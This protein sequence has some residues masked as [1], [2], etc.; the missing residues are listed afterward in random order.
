[1]RDNLA[2]RR[3]AAR[4]LAALQAA[5]GVRLPLS[6]GRI[7]DTELV[8]TLIHD[9][10]PDEAPEQAWAL[11]NGY[12]FPALADAGDEARRA[13]AICRLRLP[14]TLGRG[15]WQRQIAR[16]AMLPP[17]Y[18]L[19]SIA[20]GAVTRQTTA[21]VPERLD[22]MR[23]ALRTAPAWQER[24]ARYA[25]AGVH[26]FY[27]DREPHEVEIPGRIADLARSAPQLTL[28]RNGSERLPLSVSQVELEETATWMDQVAVGTIAAQDWYKRIHDARIAAIT[29]DG[30]ARRST[31]DVDGLLHLIGMVASG[32]SSLFTVLAVHLARQ[33]K[34]VTIV[35]GDVAALLR[36]LAIFEIFR[37]ADT[38]VQAIP[39]IGRSTRT[40]HLNRLHV[41][42]AQRAGEAT[43]SLSHP[44]YSMLSTICPL[45]GLR[46]DVTPIPPGKEP[47][48]SLYARADADDPAAGFDESGHGRRDCPVMP[49]CPVHAPTRALGDAHIWLATPASL[50]A[51]SP[52][53]PLVAEQLR[54]AELIMRGSD[55]CLI[56]EAD[57]V[58]IQSDDRFAQ[59]E[60]LVGP[61]DSWLDRL[62]NQVARQVYRSGRPEIGRSRTVDRWLTAHRN[63]QQ[64]VDRLYGWLRTHAA[65]RQWL[66]DS[67]FSGQR[68]LQR[69]AREIE[70]MGLASGPFEEAATAFELFGSGS[71]N[72]RA[73]V[74][75]PRAWRDAI[76]TELDS[77]DQDAALALI[78]VWL[79]NTLEWPT[80][81]TQQQL[82]VLAHRTL[83]AMIVSVLDH[84]LQDMVEEWNEASSTIDLDRGSGGLFYAPSDALVRQ[85]PEPA[86]GRVVGFQYW[87]LQGSGNGELRFFHIKGLGRA[88]LY[89]IHD[90][91]R[92]SDGIAG[93]HVVLASGTSWAPTSWR[94]HLHVP[95]GAVLLPNRTDA[96]AQT[97]CFF[98]PLPDPD[99]QQKM[100]T[101]SGLPPEARLRNMRMMVRELARKRGIKGLSMFDQEFALLPTHR[102]RILLIVG[103]Y[104]EAE[105]VAQTLSDAL[106]AK[107][108]EQ[109][110]ALW[111][112][113]AGE[114]QWDQP[115]DKLLRS[116][117]KDMAGHT[118]RFLVAPLQAIERGHN[119]LSLDFPQQAAIGSVYFLARPFPVPGDPHTAV[120][121]INAWAMDRAPL[122]D[123]PTIG[124]AGQ[125]LRGEA[126]NLWDT[127]LAEKETYK[128][129]LNR[130][131]ILWTELVLVWQTI[132]RLL[133]GGVQA[134]VHFI[135]GKW[136]E[137]S[138]N[139]PGAGSDRDTSRTS[140]LL[141][142][143][144]ILL[145][146]IADPDPARRA[147]AQ[148]LYG[149]FLHA[150]SGIKGVRRA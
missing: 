21:I 123:D 132:G 16:Y 42:D 146:A 18:A 110:L 10:L 32:K 84:A 89:Q 117:L 112:D 62:Y 3:V 128:D 70:Q 90:G 27:I 5:D 72:R 118:A 66:G 74:A 129:S 71:I 69:I 22:A 75:P 104:R 26:R 30:L 64:A 24:R 142:F 7:L 63:T 96:A 106:G 143:E 11:L 46:R 144:E 60:V 120:Q 150:L 55:V 131:A 1:M 92:L 125:A 15:A 8:L 19:Y 149:P 135:D 115:P 65:T 85:V 67:Y 76:S 52:Q 122:L 33:G 93:P 48:T 88:L 116:L 49:V 83:L 148:A 140:M 13:V 44:G 57:L 107:P 4:D 109:V 2:W 41:A 141:G 98:T 36:E 103:R 23:A 25:E 113:S 124:G 34:R 139:L 59:M 81:P 50:M 145:N 31:L 37:Q 43:L 136:A 95:P 79:R 40:Q 53:T 9:Y 133:R 12:P 20:T 126:R 102:Q 54:Y 94:Y 111:P 87:D 39:L 28:P 6:P 130:S 99:Q 138:A 134:R 78:G 47:C 108:G 73:E 101:V 14:E 29:D 61:H 105:E 35:M 100:L 91:L 119:I 121:K 86:M 51:A 127:I 77:A 17:G 45:D 38:R 147:I 137:A 56:D 97:E 68:L 80:A 58:Q 82:D 114:A